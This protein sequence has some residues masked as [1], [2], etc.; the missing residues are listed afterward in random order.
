MNDVSDA[1]GMMMKWFICSWELR[2]SK[3]HF[4]ALQIF[5]CAASRTGRRADDP[6]QVPV[7]VEEKRKKRERVSKKNFRSVHTKLSILLIPIYSNPN[8]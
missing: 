2:R 3:D 1:F 8:G 7:D 6:S 5:H 4:R